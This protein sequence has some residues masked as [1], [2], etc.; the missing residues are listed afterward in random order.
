MIN[1]VIFDMGGTLLHY[2]DGDEAGFREVTHRGLRAIRSDLVARGLTP[3]PEDRFVAAIDAHIGAT[4]MASMQTLSGGS[5]ETPVREAVAGM[6]ITV[7]DRLWSD[8]RRQF[9]AVIDEIVSPRQG[10]RE[11]LAA[12]DAGGYRLGLLSNT[13]WASDLHDR[14]LEA[15]GLL[16][17][18]P[19]RVYSC[20]EAHVKPHPAIF[21]ETLARM[22]ASASE[23][24]YVG[25]RLDTDVVGAQ[26]AGMR[27]VLIRSPYQDQEAE[28]AGPDAIIDELP[29]LPAALAALA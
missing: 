11:T 23:A 17:Y 7:D 9:Y 18:L 28:T 8:L 16:E 13:F 19:V 3:P 25:D 24:V 15:L 26:R 22:G 27:A 10:V 1:A 21:Q 29:D 12:L 4:Y 2:Q 14:H 6:G 5:L 20:E